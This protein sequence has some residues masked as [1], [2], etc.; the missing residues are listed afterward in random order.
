VKEK[1]R[2]NKEKKDKKKGEARG[3]DMRG[4]KSTQGLLKSP[5]MHIKVPRGTSSS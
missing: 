5:L 2:T 3:K 4:K 1:V